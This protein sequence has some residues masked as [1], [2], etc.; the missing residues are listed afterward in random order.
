MWIYTYHGQEYD[1]L[2]LDMST[3]PDKLPV[4]FV[5]ERVTSVKCNGHDLVE[6]NSIRTVILR[7]A[8]LHPV[9]ESEVQC[10]GSFPMPL[11]ANLCP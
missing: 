3:Q 5:A 9:V 1:L 4:Q 6:R 7:D 11:T 10:I 8:A 2:A